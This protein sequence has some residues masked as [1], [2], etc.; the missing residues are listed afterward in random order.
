[1]RDAPERGMG[2]FP[3]C[4]QFDFLKISISYHPVKSTFLTLHKN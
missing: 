2:A 4:S 3:L 1:M